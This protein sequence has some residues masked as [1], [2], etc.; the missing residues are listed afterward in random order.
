[1][2]MQI[3]FMYIFI[4]LFNFENWPIFN[5]DDL[6]KKKYYDVDDTLVDDIAGKVVGIYI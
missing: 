4:S 2:Y 6:V 5:C 1:M 3:I